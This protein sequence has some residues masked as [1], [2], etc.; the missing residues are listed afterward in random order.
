MHYEYNIT[1]HLGNIR[2]VFNDQVVEVQRKFRTCFGKN[3]LNFI[4]M[5]NIFLFSIFLFLF[6]Q[7]KITCYSP[8]NKI[9][10]IN[11][12]NNPIYCVPISELNLDYATT[13]SIK[14]NARFFKIIKEGRIGF[15]HYCKEAKRREGSVLIYIFDAQTIETGN[16]TN[17][18][19]SVA[20][21]K[22]D[23]TYKELINKNCALTINS[24]ILKKK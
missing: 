14:H 15:N 13:F 7:P 3:V 1:E 4:F 23:I 16:K 11:E 21:G 20:I 5:K 18:F 2:A 9:Y 24:K 10:I 17:N 8:K 6:V 12:L 19:D 22:I